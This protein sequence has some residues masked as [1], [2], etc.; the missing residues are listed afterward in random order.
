MKHRLFRGIAFVLLIFITNLLQGVIP[1]HERSAL[2][3]IY[4]STNGDDWF[5]NYTW[6]TP[7]L[8]ADGFSKPGTEGN[9]SGIT[10]SGDSVIGICM[11][12][13]D[14]KGTLPAELG[15]LSN[16][17]DLNLGFNYLEGEIPASLGNLSKLERLILVENRLTGS[18]PAQLGNLVNLT[19]LNLGYNDLT[20]PIP[21]EIGNL[22]NLTSLWLVDN[23]LNGDVP[24][25]F[26]NFAKTPDFQLNIDFNCLTATDPDVIG[27]LDTQSPNW[28][29]LQDKCAGI[30]PEI[31]V[32][33]PNGGENWIVGSS[34]AIT[35]STSGMVGSVIIEYSTDGGSNWSTIV[36]STGNTGSYSWTVPDAE[37]SKC[38]VRISE[39]ADGSPSDSS[40]G[41]FSISTSAPGIIS[42]SR[43][44]LRFGAT[45]SGKVTKPQ[46]I[47]INDS[48]NCT[49]A[50]TTSSDSTWF[51]CDKAS[52]TGDD[53][54][55]VSVDP[56][57]LATGTHSGMITVQ[58][59]YPNSTVYNIITAYLVVMDDKYDEK[60]FGQFS[61]PLEGAIVRGSI[62]VTGW[63]LD[64]VGIE[65]LKI[66]REAGPNNLVYI[67]DA[68][69][70][71][72]ARPDVEAAYQYTPANYNAGWG[73]M[74]LTNYLPNGGNGTFTLHAIATDVAGNRFTL[75]TR[76]ITADNANAVKPF[77]A[78]ETPAQ[79][80]TASGNGFI[81]WGWALTPGSNTIPTDGST[82]YV[83]IDG[84][85]IGHPTYNIYREDIAGFFP[86]YT[87]SGGAIGYFKLDT[88]SY[89]SG[90]HTIQWTVTDNAGNTDGIGSRFFSVLNT[91]GSSSRAGQSPEGIASAAEPGNLLGI[92]I[93]RK[94][95]IRVRKGYGESEPRTLLPDEKGDFVINSRELE[96]IE[97]HLSSPGFG[98]VIIPVSRLP[99]GSTFD[100][101]RGILYWQPGAGYVGRYTLDFV[102]NTG[103]GRPHL[104][105][106]IV[107][108]QPGQ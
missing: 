107:D 104:K 19:S 94:E 1:A 49:L 33:T 40:D 84:V 51:T 22:V 75:G 27:W 67:D 72:G 81:N 30:T 71:E 2:I 10:V 65:S 99:I 69:F 63:A 16:L 92:P 47:W 53:V 29:L 35:W 38:R 106:V 45:T 12:L 55:R 8:A 18:I 60:P 13:N 46:R 5:S 34:K 36:A 23:Y 68:V 6:K 62:A 20:G 105:R 97:L 56:T 100:A 102:E 59:E 3:A 70:V 76:T 26:T 21:T 31:I 37:S 54:L 95:P 77:G 42:L 25:S 39:A 43:N 80:G 14:L 11:Q 58:V 41:N 28:D 86:G 24:S 73:Y 79:G 74:L 98:T 66:Y 50:W 17:E 52:G 7:P 103:T 87:N 4:N 57:G 108:I 82:I 61:T 93:N 78:I 85:K 88:T 89:E 9:W 90:T 101:R 44:L 96:R 32:S 64:D 48:G 15:N 83:W 91:G